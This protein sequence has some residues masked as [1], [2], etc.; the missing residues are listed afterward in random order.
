VKIDTD[1]IVLYGDFAK[2]LEAL[3]KNGWTGASIRYVVNQV[4]WKAN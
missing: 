4:F 1:E 2:V 3:A